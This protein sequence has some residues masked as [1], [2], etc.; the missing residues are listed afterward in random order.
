MMFSPCLF[1][2]EARNSAEISIFTLVQITGL[3]IMLVGFILESLA[4]H[5]KSTF[6]R[7]QPQRFCDSGLY[8]WV[9]S[10]NYLGEILFWCG[11][12]VAGWLAYD[13]V[14]K[15]VIA[16]LGLIGIIF[17]MII[18]TRRLEIKQSA[19]YGDMPEFQTYIRNVPIL[20]PNT[21]IFSI[22]FLDWL[23]FT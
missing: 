16:S 2:F 19:R 23:P 20:F 15:W 6:K 5:Q 11:N 17:I 13:S 10:P 22:K 21:K 7:S 8:R 14:S 1:N 9:R 3:F 18:S 12:G 4:D